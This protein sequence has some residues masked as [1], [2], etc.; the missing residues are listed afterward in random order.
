MTDNVLKG[1]KNLK[2]IFKISSISTEKE[3][4]KNEVSGRKM[5]SLF[6]EFKEFHLKLLSE[7]SRRIIK[8]Q[9]KLEMCVY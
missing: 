1:K 3:K 9:A 7:Y 4:L 6:K 8:R 5:M 2:G